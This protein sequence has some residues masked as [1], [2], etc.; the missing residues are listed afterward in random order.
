MLAHRNSTALIGRKASV[1]RVRTIS[2]CRPLSVRCQGHSDT[3]TSGDNSQHPSSSSSWGALPTIGARA[4]GAGACASSLFVFPGLHAFGSGGNRPP[5]GG[6][7]GGD[8]GG[9]G[10]FGQQPLYDLAADDKEK[11]E[12]ESLDEETPDE[13]PKGKDKGADE[14]WKELLTPSDQQEELPGQ[15]TGTNR[16]VEISIEGWPAVGA[17]PKLVRAGKACFA[18]AWASSPCP[19][20][21]LMHC[22]HAIS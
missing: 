2:S 9:S 17:L 18:M 21:Y 19:S 15:R 12:E 20:P 8:G 7:G 5:G 22:M 11:S 4:V 16:C 3:S 6:G 13:E 1:S 14:A 10:G